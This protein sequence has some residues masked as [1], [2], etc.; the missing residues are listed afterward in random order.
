MR[1]PR[2]QRRI[3]RERLVDAASAISCASSPLSLSRTTFCS[4]RWTSTVVSETTAAEQHPRSGGSS[5]THRVRVLAARQIQASGRSQPRNASSPRPSVQLGPEHPAAATAR[6]N[7]AF[8]YWPAGRTGEAVTLGEAVSR[9][10]RTTPR[11]RAPRHAHRAREPRLSPTGRPGRNPGA[12]TL[13][14]AVLADRERLPRPRAPPTHSAR[15]RT[16]PAPTGRPGAPARRSAPPR[17]V[18]ADRERLLGPDRPD[19]PH[20]PREPRHLLPGRPGAPGRRS[21][22]RAVLA[23]RERCSAPSTPTPSKRARTSP[24]PTGRPDAPRSRPPPSDGA[25]R[26]RTATRP[27]PPRHPTRPRQPRRLPTRP[28]GPGRRSQLLEGSSTDSERLIGPDHHNTLTARANLATYY[29][30]AGRTEEARPA[31]RANPRR[32]RTP[33]RPRTP[34]TLTAR[35]NL[36]TFLHWAA[37]RTEEAVDLRKTVLADHGHASSAPNTQHPQDPHQP[38]PASYQAAGRTRE[39]SSSSSERSP[40]TN[41]AWAPNAPT[42]ALPRACWTSCV[43]TSPS[44]RQVRARRAAAIRGF[45]APAPSPSPPGRVAGRV[46]RDRGEAVRPGAELLGAE[47][48]REGERVGARLRVHAQRAR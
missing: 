31:P 14:E 37:G 9:R 2:G 26:P 6:A 36:A 35:A 29:W 7:L 15:A 21:P 32:P 23:D 3:V 12:V 13:E 11:P 17:R 19:T 27:R 41:A 16:S 44:R 47:L 24:P 42:P 45:S 46:D 4:S 34:N 39:P 1:P 20:H 30:A 22:S 48:G 38:P 40:T 43:K 18:L 28:G 33:H 5:P 25:H 8:S 10:P